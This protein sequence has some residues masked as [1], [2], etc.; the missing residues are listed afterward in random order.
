MP[1]T[2]TF[3]GIQLHN[4]DVARKP[5]YFSLSLAFDAIQ[6]KKDLILR[7]PLIH[8][9]SVET[10]SILASY[11]CHNF[12]H[13]MAMLCKYQKPLGA[14][15][16]GQEEKP[17]KIQEKNSHSGRFLLLSPFLSFFVFWTTTEKKKIKTRKHENMESENWNW[18]GNC[19][20]FF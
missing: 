9:G 11:C 12:C 18:I 7:P 5:L 14:V 10:F 15:M 8:F 19:S 4:I 17:G 2:L 6:G 1:L 3:C 16:S 20:L 13:R